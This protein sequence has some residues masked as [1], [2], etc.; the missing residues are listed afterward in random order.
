[1]RRSCSWVRERGRPRGS[2][3][4]TVNCRS[5]VK[6]GRQIVAM[7]KEGYQHLFQGL[8]SVGQAPRFGMRRRAAAGAVPRD[9]VTRFTVPQL[10]EHRPAVAGFR[11]G[12][13]RRCDHV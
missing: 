5:S 3:T 2:L 10:Q 1:M 11:T 9:S 6:D 13:P 8:E 7:E 12:S 4:S